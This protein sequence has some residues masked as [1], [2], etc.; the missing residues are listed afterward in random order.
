MFL[1]SKKKK[2]LLLLRFLRYLRTFRGPSWVFLGN[3]KNPGYFCDF[4]DI[5]G[6]F[7]VLL[8]FF[9][10]QKKILVTFAIFAI[11]ADISGPFMGVFR[12]HEK[13]LLLLRFLRC[14]I[15]GHFGVLLGFFCFQKKILVTFAIF[16]IFADISGP[17]MGVFREHEKSLLLLRFLRYLRTFRGPSW[18][19]LFPSLD[20]C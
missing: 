7:G 16:A 4:C 10:F 12:E 18:L 13:S 17:F 20:S 19:L 14:D 5:C 1:P 15:W 2:Y 11:F 6:H 8:G 9:C 3:M